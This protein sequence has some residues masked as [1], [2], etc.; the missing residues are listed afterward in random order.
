MR[1]LH[2]TTYDY[3]G[4]GLAV[5]RLHRALLD[6]G[7]NSAV[8]VQNKNLDEPFVY[9]AEKAGFNSSWKPKCV[10]VRVLVKILRHFGLMLSKKDKYEREFR[11]AAKGITKLCYTSPISSYDLSE[12]PLVQEA[13]IIHLHW[14]ARFVD[15]E[16]FFKLVKKPIVWTFHDENIGFGG[17]HY[18]MDKNLY[19]NKLKSIED[20]YAAIK[21]KSLSCRSD[22]NVVALSSVMADF[23]QH[24]SFLKNN[25]ISVIHNS[26][27]YGVF[28]PFDKNLSREVFNIPA[29]NKVFAFCC[30]SLSDERKGLRELISALEL[31]DMSDL[32]LLC[33][34]D[35]PLPIRTSLNVICTGTIS[36]ANLLALIYSCADIFVM[37]SFQEAFAQTPLEAMACGLPVIAFPCSGTEELINENNGIRCSDFT[38]GALVKGLRK[39][40]EKKY[41]SDVI[42]QDVISRFS[43]Q[44][45][46]GKYIELYRSILSVR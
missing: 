5:L 25:P 24:K 33:V 43:P 8:L 12:H 22:I 10:F 20:E 1:I 30:V 44:K 14:I 37:P 45:I 39:A 21:E 19:Y 23:C 17:F 27:N 42:R 3:G 16:T 29:N 38:V 46:A 2:I 18:E 7:V 36:N 41:D 11:I 6:V 26:V 28:R 4:A 15:Y 35:G 40:L 9:K 31:L 32:S 13:D 34:G